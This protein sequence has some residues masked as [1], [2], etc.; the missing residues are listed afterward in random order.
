M[1]DKKD[2]INGTWYLGRCRNSHI[3]MWDGNKFLFFNNSFGS[4]YREEIEHYFDVK[5][6]GFDGFI[7]IEEV[8]ILDYKIT[9]KE[10]DGVD[11]RNRY[12]KLYLEKNSESLRGEV[13]VDIPEYEELYQASSFG[14]IRKYNGTIM[15]QSFNQ[16]YLVLGLTKDKVRKNFRVHRL[17]AMCFSDSPEYGCDE[18]DHINGVK[19][20]N[21]AINLRW[22]DRKTN[23]RSMYQNGVV[24][25]KL[26]M[27]IVNRIREE[28][29]LGNKQ[30]KDIAKEYGLAPSTISDIKNNKK[31][32]V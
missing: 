26:T 9:N 10:R 4:Y 28:I 25:K 23:A 3:G 32:V 11:Y 13:W 22:V 12:R 17:I 27:D 21:R 15:S 18:V 8:K 30:Q 1:I 7:P 24:K 29:K 19:T 31:W 6:S 14:R 16:N 5:D 2:L 20:D